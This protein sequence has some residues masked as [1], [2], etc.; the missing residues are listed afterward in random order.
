MGLIKL[1][2]GGFLV[3]YGGKKVLESVCSLNRRIVLI[4]F[5]RHYDLLS[6]IMTLIQWIMKNRDGILGCYSFKISQRSNAKRWKT[7]S[8]CH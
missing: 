5:I 8:E 1:C 4:P 6:G 3:Y 7:I 2:F